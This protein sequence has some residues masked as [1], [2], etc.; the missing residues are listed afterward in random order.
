MLDVYGYMQILKNYIQILLRLHLG[1]DI[2]K[3]QSESMQYPYL[4]FRL[5]ATVAESLQLD[6]QKLW[7]YFINISTNVIQKKTLR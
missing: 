3:C 1:L 6:M 2:A 4:V 5:T 7:S